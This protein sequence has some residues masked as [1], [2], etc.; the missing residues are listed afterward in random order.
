MAGES[1]HRGILLLGPHVAEAVSSSQS[2]EYFWVSNC[3]A[4]VLESVPKVLGSL[5]WAMS[6]EAEA[7]AA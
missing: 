2:A 3:L 6:L 5:F 7:L 1:P 4:E